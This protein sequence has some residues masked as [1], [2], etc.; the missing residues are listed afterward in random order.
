M[1]GFTFRV[2]PLAYNDDNHKENPVNACK[3]NKFGELSQFRRSESHYLCVFECRKEQELCVCV[4]F[5]GRNT[6]TAFY[7]YRLLSFF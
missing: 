2:S 5:A 3:I 1:M 6:L 7:K 4:A